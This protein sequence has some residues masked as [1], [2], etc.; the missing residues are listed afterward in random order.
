MWEGAVR[1]QADDV[2]RAT[3]MLSL[4]ILCEVDGEL[5]VGVV[6]DSVP[7]PNGGD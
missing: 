7:R 2:E 5:E 6:R 3:E 1:S 4:A